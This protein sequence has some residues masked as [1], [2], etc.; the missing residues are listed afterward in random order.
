MI[1]VTVQLEDVNG[2]TLYDELD[3][4]EETVLKDVVRNALTRNGFDVAVVDISD[5]GF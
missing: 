4:E 1:I 5:D 3:P 2:K